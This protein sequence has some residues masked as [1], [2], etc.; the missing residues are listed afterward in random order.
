[1]LW[2]ASL[3]KNHFNLLAKRKIV[4]D[5][6]FQHIDFIVFPNIHI[7]CVLYMLWYWYWYW[8]WYWKGYFR[9]VSFFNI[10]FFLLLKRNPVRLWNTITKLKIILT[11]LKNASMEMK[12]KL[13]GLSTDWID[14][15]SPTSMTKIKIEWEK[16]KASVWMSPH[17]C[18]TPSYLLYSSEKDFSC[19]KKSFH[20]PNNFQF[21]RKTDQRYHQC[22][23]GAVRFFFFWSNSS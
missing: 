23:C 2:S 4:I 1:M 17:S 3:G 13:C 20:Q 5:V 12:F 22:V 19:L 11:H 10:F 7:L 15:F 21:S 18:E 16:K 14:F 9:I 6:I 8:Y